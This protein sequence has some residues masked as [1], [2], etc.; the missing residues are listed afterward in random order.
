V[1]DLMK[2]LQDENAEVRHTTALTLAAIGAEPN[3]IIAG[4][5]DCLA[6]EDIYMRS[7]AAATLREIAPDR[8][9][10]VQAE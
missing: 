2:Y 5:S 4:L 7:I 10:Y 1:P 6:A 9:W 8:V 3:S